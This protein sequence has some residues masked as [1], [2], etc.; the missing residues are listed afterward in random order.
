MKRTLTSVV[1]F[2]AIVKLVGCGREAEAPIEVGVNPKDLSYANPRLRSLVVH[3]DEA[4]RRA[5]PEWGETPLLKQERKKS[6]DARGT[7]D[8]DSYKARWNS[9]PSTQSKDNED[10]FI[11]P[12]H[13]LSINLWTGDPPDNSER[14][15]EVSLR[16]EYHPKT[17][18]GAR[19][20]LGASVYAQDF[21]SIL[22]FEC[23]KGS[24]RTLDL[25]KPS[26]SGRITITDVPDEKIDLSYGYSA[27]LKDRRF[28]RKT[29]RE[30]WRSPEDFRRVALESLD[31]LEETVQS[32]FAAGGVISKSPWVS[33]FDPRRGDPRAGV[34]S[35]LKKPL[36][37]AKRKEALK[38]ILKEIAGKRKAIKSDYREMHA[39]IVKALPLGECLEGMLRAHD[40]SNANPPH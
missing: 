13:R 3:M 27:K 7:P 29:L 6:K 12:N 17:G 20:I 34:P 32:R 15:A 11:A 1:L 25:Q 21:F 38:T 22:L 19:C 5:Q 37:E 28:D 35:H 33:P 36:S 39:A 8:H 24:G 10:L 23:P 30:L 2:L 18:W 9:N 4:I 40:S 31:Q 14:I 16:G 26:L